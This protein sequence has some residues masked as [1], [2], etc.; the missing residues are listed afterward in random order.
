MDKRL[1]VGGLPYS[2]DDKGL[3]ELFAPYGVVE[4]A[5]V[6]ID[7]DSGRSKGFGFVEM[8]TPEEAN[9]AIAKLNETDVDGRK[10]VVNIARPKE[11]RPRRDFGGRGGGF[12]SRGHGDRNSDRRDGGRNRY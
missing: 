9:A 8:A 11:D 2:I 6:V 12:Q 10:I 5:T 3:A 1:F 4:S 7:R